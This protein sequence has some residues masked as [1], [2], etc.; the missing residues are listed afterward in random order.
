MDWNQQFED[1]MKTWADSQQKA[2]DN[3]FN[4]MQGFGKSQSTRA[5][6][7]TLDIGE[8]M[9]KDILKMQNQWLASWVDGLAKMSGVPA[10]AVESAR[11]FQEMAARWNTTQAE[12]LEN[13]FGVLKKF[14][15][16]SPSDNWSGI[17]QNMFK[18]WQDTTQNIMDAQMKWMQSWMEQSRKPDNG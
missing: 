15:P 1:T 12:L 5:W 16:T 8:S 13:W 11:Q 3:F 18:T 6:E 2:W 14:A 10:Q 7:S 17:P 4:M 9:M